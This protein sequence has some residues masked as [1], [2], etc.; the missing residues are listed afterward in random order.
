MTNFVRLE[1]GKDNGLFEYEVR[2]DPPAH[3]QNLRFQLLNQQ[4][5]VIGKTKTFDGV[6]LCLPMQLPDQVTQLT[7]INSNDD[8]PVVLT[9][10][11]KGKRKFSECIQFYG[12]LFSNIMKILKFVRFGTKDFDPTEPKVV[13]QH[14]LE[15]WPGYVTG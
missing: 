3:A 10:I 14:K 4:A 12:I 6:K 7:S 13:P 15:I 11:Y 1:V 5:E 2:F 8:T 9:L